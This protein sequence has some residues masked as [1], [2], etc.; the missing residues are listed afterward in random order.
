MLNPTQ[1]AD[2]LEQQWLSAEHGAYPASESASADA[3]AGA[4]SHWFMTSQ[5]A[6]FPV[7]TAIARRSMLTALATPAL[8][9]QSPVA[10]GQQLANALMLYITGQLYGVGVAAPPAATGAAGAVLGSAFANLNLNRQQRAQLMASAV[11]L[12]AVSTV[13]NFSNLP[14][15]APVS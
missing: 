15:A 13:V 4:V 7:L 6:G 14:F 8:A 10:A 1:L 9:A 11:Q 12:M 5:A 3:F 2:Q